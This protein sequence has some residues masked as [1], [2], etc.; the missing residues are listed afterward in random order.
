[1]GALTFKGQ[2]YTAEN[3]DVAGAEADMWALGVDYA[4]SKRTTLYGAYTSMDNGANMNFTPF[5]GGHGDN[6]GTVSG[7]D[8]NGFS[9]GVV[10]KF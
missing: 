6:P 8:P 3:D 10:H 9:L 2:Y 7:G 4:L 1:M 5:G